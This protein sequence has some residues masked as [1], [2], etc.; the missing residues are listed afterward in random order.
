LWSEVES[1][2][3]S[4]IDDVKGDDA[5][6]VLPERTSQLLSS[7]QN[8]YTNDAANSTISSLVEDLAAKLFAT[9]VGKSLDTEG[10]YTT[11]YLSY[12]KTG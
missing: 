3:V 2:A 6:M 5:N 10:D 4:S 9:T 12:E 8:V 7:M 1:F 11:P